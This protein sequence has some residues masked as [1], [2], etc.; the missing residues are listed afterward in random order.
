MSKPSQ[1]M[2]RNSLVSILCSCSRSLN[3]QLQYFKQ[4]LKATLNQALQSTV[5]I[6][7]CLIG[8]MLQY[9]VFKSFRFSTEINRLMRDNAYTWISVCLGH[10][11]KEA[12][13]MN[14]A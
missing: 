3:S 10:M 9:S 14:A 4:Q 2:D 6:S 12:G 11:M 7:K 8:Y 13:Q 5:G 1:G